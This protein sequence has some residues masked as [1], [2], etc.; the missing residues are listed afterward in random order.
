V[1]LPSIRRLIPGARNM[2]KTTGT[3]MAI[4]ITKN[5][6]NSRDTGARS[7]LVG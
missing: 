7:G 4:K 2:A 1:V 3:P 6:K 5:Q